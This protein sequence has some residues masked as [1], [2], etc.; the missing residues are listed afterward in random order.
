MISMTDFNEIIKLRNQSF[1]HEEI[2]KA[3]G[4]SERTVGRYLSTGKIPVYER[5]KPTRK[6]PFEEYKDRVQELFNKD[7]NGR[8]PRC[9]DVYR[10]I[11]KEGYTGS[12]R[13]VER[14]TKDLRRQLKGKGEIYFEQEVPYGKMIEGDFTAFN[15]P[16]VNGVEKRHLWVMSLKRSKGSH[17]TSFQNETF[18]SF[19]EG[20]QKGFDF[21]GGVPSIYRLDNL[22]PAVK[23]ILRNKRVVTHKFNQLR[24]HYDFEASFCRPAAGND[25][26]TVE[27][28]N[29]HFKAYLYY[30]IKVENRV[31]KGDDDFDAYLNEKV[32]EYCEPKKNEIEK[33]KLS[34]KNLPVNPFPAFSTEV[35]NVNK[36]GFI[37]VANRRYSVPVKYKLCKVEIR[38]Y[39]KR[40]EIFYNGQKIKEHKRFTERSLKPVIDFRDHID[41]LL[42]KPGA[43]T[44]YKHKDAFFP[45][46]SFKE[47]YIRNSDNKNYLKCL[48]LCKDRTIVEVECAVNIVLDESHI[49]SYEKL[50]SLIRPKEDVSA[51][52]NSIIPLRPS[53]DHY[54]HL[55]NNEHKG[56]ENHGYNDR[57]LLK[58]VEASSLSNQ[59]H[60]G[61]GSC[62]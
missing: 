15:V 14:K 57:V 2:A 27:A 58:T 62:N 43:F 7:I 3:I 25:K 54:D 49:P 37:R 40:I 39:S 20:T 48:A 50:F 35:C 21:F 22:T 56:E 13:N 31:F 51:N 17:A 1:T 12:R 52:V 10:T 55:L 41:A 46:E 60:E 30:E 59:L 29:K 61:S 42:K 33:E 11:V 34:L 19:A 24:E 4:C 45:T 9:V 5:S 6:D 16:F 38:L 26:G 28:T 53:L 36:Y 44:H 8:M 23:K 47:L 32:K 18:E